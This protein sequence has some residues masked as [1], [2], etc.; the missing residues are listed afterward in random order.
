MTFNEDFWDNRYIDKNTGWDIGYVSTPLKTYFDQLENKDLKILI[1]GGGNSY[2]AE[3]LHNLGFKNVYVVDISSIPLQGL[4][5]RL[6]DFPSK[7]L[8][9]ANFF[10]LDMAFDLIIEQTFFCALD[11]KLRSQYVKRSHQLLNKNGKIVGLLFND[12]L[13]ED[14]PPFGGNKKEYITCFNP[15]FNIEIMALCYNSIKPRA[16]ME[17]F[18]KMIK[19]E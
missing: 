19:K 3:Y 7:H 15:M 9:H 14:H 8:I 16:D 1:P 5:K 4:Q 13:N 6:P 2:E 12:P 10:D 18:I 11:P 17:L